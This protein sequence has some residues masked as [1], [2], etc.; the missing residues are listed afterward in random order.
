MDDYKVYLAN[1]GKYNEGELVG[2]W[3][4]F[5]I[6]EDE[7]IEKLGLDESYEE[8]AVHDYE[9]PI[10]LPESISIDELNDMYEKI[11][12]LPAHIVD[13][14]EEFV[15]YFGSLEEIDEEKV[16]LYED[17]STMLDVAY[18]KVDEFEVFGSLLDDVRQYFNYGA[19]AS[20]LEIDGY[21]IET[22]NG[23]CEVKS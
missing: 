10:K 20:D 14:L 16:V 9:F 13:N 19:Y 22:S 17:C 7:V 5:P 12:E 3:F 6:F 11:E 23:M 8:Y 21:W 4:D 18:M 2:A 15:S 1:L